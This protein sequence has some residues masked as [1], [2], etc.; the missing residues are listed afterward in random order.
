MLNKHKKQ[1]PTSVL[2]RR[3]VHACVGAGHTA[4][5]ATSQWV[6]EQPLEAVRGRRGEA[7]L[8]KYERV[9]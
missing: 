6:V 5:R 2:A 9:Y 4:G 8:M 3:S 1:C 7:G